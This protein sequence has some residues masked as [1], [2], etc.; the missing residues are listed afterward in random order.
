[1]RQ[2]V[3]TILKQS[4]RI[5]VSDKAD[6]ILV[7]WDSI[8]RSLMGATGKPNRYYPMDSN[9]LAVQSALPAPCACPV[10]AP[11]S[12]T[13]CPLLGYG[14][15]EGGRCEEINSALVLIL[16]GVCLP[17]GGGQEPCY[18]QFYRSP[19]E[20]HLSCFGR[21]VGICVPM[22]IGG[23][24]QDSLLAVPCSVLLDVA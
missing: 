20:S 21:C 17:I 16:F 7:C 2:S 13:V 1:M 19:K 10:I 11:V 18:E 6:I 5:L 23:A 24:L 14:G 3:P 22:A 8:G 15:C 12:G 4:L 9:G